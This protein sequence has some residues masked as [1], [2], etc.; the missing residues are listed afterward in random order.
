MHNNQICIYFYHQMY[1]YAMQH[2]V[3]IL[4]TYWFIRIICT[5]LYNLVILTICS[6]IIHSSML[7]LHW[8]IKF[9]SFTLMN[10]IQRIF[11][12]KIGWQSSQNIYNSNC[13][14]PGLANNNRFRARSGLQLM[15]TSAN[16]LYWDYLFRKHCCDFL[17]QPI[18]S[19]GT[20]NQTKLIDFSNLKEIEARI[21]TNPDSDRTLNR[22]L[23]TKPGICQFLL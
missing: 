14:I 4:T 8:V 11:G 17:T 12:W 21:A 19:H 23:Y 7:W 3:K 9:F 16:E 2:V 13:Q 1:L 22:A 5:T 20:V 18:K 15:D 10:I 6:E